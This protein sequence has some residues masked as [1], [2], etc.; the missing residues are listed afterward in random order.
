MMVI[1]QNEVFSISL[2]SLFQEKEIS[3]AIL[4]DPSVNANHAMTH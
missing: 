4:V 3:R 1:I 2:L